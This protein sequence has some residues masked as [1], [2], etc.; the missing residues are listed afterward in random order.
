L[1]E[2]RKVI[3]SRRCTK[4]TSPSPFF[5]PLLS[6]IHRKPRGDEEEDDEDEKDEDERE[7]EKALLSNVG[8]KWRWMETGVDAGDGLGR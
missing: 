6:F 5:F 2:K 8:G 4:S 3:W 7:E 1:S